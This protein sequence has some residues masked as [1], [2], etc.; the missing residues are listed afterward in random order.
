MIEEWKDIP[1]YEGLY[2]V[3]NMGNVK[4]LNYNHTGKERILKTRLD[5][6][7]YIRLNLFNVKRKTEKV[8]QLVALTFLAWDKSK[9][10]LIRHLNHDKTDN[11]LENLCVGTI[12]ENNTD[13]RIDPGVNWRGAPYN[14]WVAQICIC[15]KKLHLGH[16]V[17]KQDGLDM[18]QKALANTHLYDGDAKAFRF[19]LSQL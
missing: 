6:D 13:Y 14:K 11:R 12:Y 16:F 9:Y 10:P 3:S 1:G 17:N 15:G 19:V 2:Q 7:G 4:S 5:K 18:Y 8:H